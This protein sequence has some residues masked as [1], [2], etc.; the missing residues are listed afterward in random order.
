MMFNEQSYLYHRRHK[1]TPF[2][3][4]QQTICNLYTIQVYILLV[5]PNKARRY[6]AKIRQKLEDIRK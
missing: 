6:D 2:S 5:L 3:G 1:Y 4:L